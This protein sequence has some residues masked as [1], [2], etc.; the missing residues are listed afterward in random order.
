VKIFIIP[1]RVINALQKNT[2]SKEVTVA[3]TD[4]NTV[5]MVLT[6]RQEISVNSKL[7]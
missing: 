4:A 7:E 3:K 2:T 5:L 6:K 1:L